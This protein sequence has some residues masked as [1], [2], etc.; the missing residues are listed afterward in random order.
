MKKLFL[1]IILVLVLSIPCLAAEPEVRG[2]WVSTVYNLDYPSQAG[3]STADMMQEADEIIDS[4][5]AAGMN[6]IILQVRPC[7]DAIYPSE[8]FPWSQYI[9]GIQGQAP[10]GGFDPLD[11]Y[12]DQCHSRGIELHAWVNPYR[13]TVK[14]FTSIDDGLATLSPQHPAT[15]HPEWVRLGAD[16]RLY[17]DPALT[18]VQEL[19]VDGVR[20]ILDNYQVDGIHIDDYFYPDGGFDDSL[21]YERF[22]AGYDNLGDFRRDN[23]NRIIEDLYRTV[24]SYGVTFGISPFGIW[25]N[26]TSNLRGSMTS[27]GQSY[28]DHYADTLKWIEEGWTDYIAPQ[29]YWEIGGSEGEFETLLKWWRNAVDGSGVDLYIGIGAYR[30]I[31]AQPSSNWYDGKE[32]TEQLDMIDI[33]GKTDGVL[34]FRQKSLDG[35]SPLH[36]HMSDR[37]TYPMPIIGKPIFYDD[38]NAFGILSPAVN[39]R[40]VENNN[41]SVECTGYSGSGIYSMTEDNFAA[42]GLRKFRYTA[43]LMIENSP[44][45]TVICENNSLVSV[46]IVC[47]D[48]I[49]SS[50]RASIT[51]IECRTTPEYTAISFFTDSAVSAKCSKSGKYL[52]LD[53]APC[54]RGILFECDEIDYMVTENKS[55]NVRYVF[56]LKQA[57][58]DCY[59][60][61]QDD[62]IILYLKY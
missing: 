5:A 7:C 28:Y 32:I 55:Y 19:I 21:S 62:R 58:Q 4:A 37:Y 13:V 26:A 17:F 40:A 54:R 41:I 43:E 51:D 39:G 35:C 25:A 44:D 50:S 48:P 2:V 47:I 57:I 8:I 15:M 56:A 30:A 52:T 18:E 10:E 33:Y 49:D 31:D 20:E 16:G 24:K 12:T 53:I 27:G 61:E 22:G 42:L 11:Y 45:V 60:E 14:S 34:F 1:T 36:E 59:I 46:K 3:I 6:T 29:L 23:V 38:Q 9:S